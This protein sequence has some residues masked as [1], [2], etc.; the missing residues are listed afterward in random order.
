MYCCLASEF[1]CCFN[2]DVI[3][4]IL[5]LLAADSYTHGIQDYVRHSISYPLLQRFQMDWDPNEQ[6]VTWR[7]SVYW[8]VVCGLQCVCSTDNV[9][10]HAPKQRL[11]FLQTFFLLM[12]PSSSMRPCSRESL[13]PYWK[14][15]SS[16]GKAT[17]LLMSITYI[18]T[19]YCTVE[20]RFY[21]LHL[22]QKFLHLYRLRMGDVLV[23]SFELD[24][25][26]RKDN[27]WGP[28]YF[29]PNG[30][31]QIISKH[32][33]SLGSFWFLRSPLVGMFGQKVGILTSS[34]NCKCSLVVPGIERD[35]K[36]SKLLLDCILIVTS[37]VPPELPMELSLA[38]NTSL[39]ALSKFGQLQ[40]FMSYLSCI[41][42][43]PDS[44]FLHW[45]FSYS[46]CWSRWYLLF[47]Q[48]RNN[49]CWEPCSSGC[50]WCWVS[51]LAYIFPNL[52]WS[53]GS[54]SQIWGDLQ[55]FR[56]FQEKLHYVS[57][58]HMPWL[59]WKMAR[60]LEI[61][62]RRRHWTLWNGLLPKAILSSTIID[63]NAHVFR[64]YNWP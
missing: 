20:L 38:V 2:I 51:N 23:L 57:P 8:Y 7:Y 31:L 32:F 1:W 50:C 41:P 10:Q 52:D 63:W 21:R 26:P 22:P 42:D 13:R 62:W 28:W 3:C 40:S 36:K 64:K 49:Y 14:S 4:R 56:K 16:Y 48:N 27:L 35:L 61:R 33:C 11:M 47:W 12:A 5:I 58:P 19:Q 18:R 30:S 53:Q 15:P 37:V 60:L 46:L 6:V 59:N 55:V 39:V 43:I 9:N 54:V 24:L 45:T 17:K 25:E 34:P 44:Y 29:P